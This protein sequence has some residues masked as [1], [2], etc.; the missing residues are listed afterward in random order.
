MIVAGVDGGKDGHRLHF[1]NTEDGEGGIVSIVIP[2][3]AAEV[4]EILIATPVVRLA[5]TPVRED[6]VLAAG[7]LKRSFG[8]NIVQASPKMVVLECL[9]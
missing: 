5:M 9:I 2:E 6:E 8:G 7:P 1:R 3:I 4:N